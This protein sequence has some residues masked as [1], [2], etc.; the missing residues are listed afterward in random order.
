MPTIAYRLHEDDCVFEAIRAQGAGGQHVN[1]VSSAVQ[2]RLDVRA[3]QLPEALK[4]RLLARADRRIS[5]DGVLV[6]KA[7][8]SRSQ[9]ANRAEALARLRALLDAAAHVPRARK[10]TEPTLASQ[11]RRVDEKVKRGRLKSLRRAAME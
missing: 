7:Q 8:G 9:V 11:R 3:A 6:I 2:L 5:G 1:K 4:A 10:A